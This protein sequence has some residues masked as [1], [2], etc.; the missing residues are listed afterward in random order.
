MQIFDKFVGRQVVQQDEVR[1]T[2]F[3]LTR[4]RSKALL[5]HCGRNYA[6]HIQYLTRVC[7]V[8][9]PLH[10]TT[11]DTTS[12]YEHFLETVKYFKCLRWQHCKM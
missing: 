2:D 9:K 5:T 4:H 11:G 6:V 8:N 7:I 3:W 10:K 12:H 1:H